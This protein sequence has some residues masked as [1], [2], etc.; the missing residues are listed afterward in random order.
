MKKSLVTA[1][2][3][4]ASSVI[5]SGCVTTGGGTPQGRVSMVD[6]SERAHLQA[7]LNMTDLMSSAERLTD[8]MLSSDAIATW[9]D[10]RPRLIVG[11]IRNRS[12]VDNIPEEELY[13]RIL[14]IIVESGVARIVDT[15]ATDFDYIMEGKIGSTTQ[16][17]SDGEE[18]RQFRIT[19]KMFSI[20][21]EL[22]GS[23]QDTSKS[24]M[25]AKRPLF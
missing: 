3:I 8:K 25:K 21:G 17:G 16:R 6:S 11:R 22:L 9:G 13:E 10:K 18:Q 24:F 12:D 20:D 2:C 14:S 1:S 19:L 15:G 4:V 23:W 7:N 5:L